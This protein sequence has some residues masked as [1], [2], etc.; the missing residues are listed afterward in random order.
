[1]LSASALADSV[2]QLVLNLCCC[3]TSRSRHA[4][5]A[6]RCSA[7]TEGT[8][9][10]RNSLFVLFVAACLLPFLGTRRPLQAAPPERTLKIKLNYTGTGVVDEKHKIYVLLFD[11]NPVM[12]ST[13]IDSTSQSTPPAPAAGVSH[14]I[15]REST[16]TKDG[17]I[18]FHAVAVSPVYAM[19]FF[20]RTGT[21]NGHADPSSGSPMGL[22]GVP[23]DKLEAIL[24]APGKPAQVIFSFDDSRL[25][26]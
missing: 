6:D 10:F 17:A 18:T 19:F 26:P 22:Y 16:A 13:L 12:A 1:M 2:Q 23:P 11:A 21:Y 3:V 5:A 7:H 15:A 14:I 25:T 24:L 9:K 20:D 4:S 8:V